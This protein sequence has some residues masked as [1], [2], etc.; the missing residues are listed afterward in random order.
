[1]KLI[2]GDCLATLRVVGHY[3]MLFADPPDNIGLGY[4]SY[5]DTL[6][7]DEYVAW[8]EELLY[9]AVD[10]APIQW[11]SFNAKWTLRFAEVFQ[12]LVRSLDGWEFKPCVQ[13]FGFYQHNKYDLGNAHRP[14]WRLRY[15]KMPLYPENIHVESERQKLGDKRAKSGGKVPGDVFD[16][17][18]VTGN[19]RQRRS[20]HPTQLHEGLVERCVRLSTP[21]SGSV[22]DPFAGTGT[23]LRVCERL[24]RDCTSI[25]L[26]RRYCGEIAEDLGMVKTGKGVWHKNGSD[27][28]ASARI[29]MVEEICHA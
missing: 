5:T 8:I 27:Y 6:P 17:P 20:W 25:E 12:G 15:N 24:G 22:I 3:D 29:N 21:E 28:S 11:W 4:N 7:E 10:H 1:M 26:D 19:S 23:T 16:F 14:L 13:T 9:E 2:H 18:R